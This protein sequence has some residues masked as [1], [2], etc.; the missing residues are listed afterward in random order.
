M[1][2][3]LAAWILHHHSVF[4]R[5]IYPAPCLECAI[6]HQ[7]KHGEILWSTR[8]ELQPRQNRL[9]MIVR[10]KTVCIAAGVGDQEGT[11]GALWGPGRVD[12]ASRCRCAG[13]HSRGHTLLH[14][15]PV[16]TSSPWPAFVSLADMSSGNDRAQSAARLVFRGQQR[17][18]GS[19]TNASF[20]WAA[21]KC[22]Q[23]VDN[24]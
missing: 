12:A 11:G 21:V 6:K 18:E 23:N 8:Q 13:G 17:G 1:C 9:G 16:S 14:V 4:I 2:H 15:S 20:T 5:F 10:G 24:A 22:S 19:V 7:R 3:C